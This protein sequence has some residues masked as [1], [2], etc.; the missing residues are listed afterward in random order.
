VAA[1]AI[2]EKMKDGNDDVTKQNRKRGAFVANLYKDDNELDE[3]KVLGGDGFDS[4]LEKGSDDDEELDEKAIKRR[5]AKLAR[6]NEVK[7][8]AKASVIATSGAGDASGGLGSSSTKISKLTLTKGS[9]AMW[10]VS[11]IH[12]GKYAIV[13]HTRNLK[14]FLPLDNDQASSLK[15]G[16]FI[17]ASVTATGTGTHEIETSG[18]LNRK[19][20]LCLTP[21]AINRSLKGTNITKNMVLQAIVHSKEA[22]GYILDL[23]LTDGAAGFLKFNKN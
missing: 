2:R 21:A 23:G 4:E 18:N 15:V 3:M 13:N 17:L 1:K 5:E 8:A 7:V 12:D 14:G 19:I 22:K 6:K 11:E 20:Q 16:Q 10:A 9:V